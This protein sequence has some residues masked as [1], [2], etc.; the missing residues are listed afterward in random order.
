MPAMDEMSEHSEVWYSLKNN[1]SIRIC[2]QMT[3]AFVNKPDVIEID[4]TIFVAF[5]FKTH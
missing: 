1:S 5:L 3:F 2:I 4:V